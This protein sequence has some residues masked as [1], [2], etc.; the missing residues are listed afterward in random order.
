M[1]TWVRLIMLAAFLVGVYVLGKTSGLTDQLTVDGIRE[2]MRQ[3]GVGGFFVFVGIFCAGQL[4]Y[5][6]GF[7][8]VM[9]AGLAYGPLWGSVA[10]VMAGIEERSTQEVTSLHG[11]PAIAPDGIEVLNPA[12]DVTPAEYVTGIITEQGVFRPDEL[13]NHF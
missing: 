4:L 12:F 2:T 9:V 7:V 5:I 3:A 13:A 11:G 8:F 6:P 10:S 1:K